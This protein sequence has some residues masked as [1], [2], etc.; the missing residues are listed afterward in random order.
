[1][2]DFLTPCRAQDARVDKRERFNRRLDAYRR[3]HEVS[4]GRYEALTSGV[5]E[6]QR[7]EQTRLLHQRWLE[8]RQARRHGGAKAGKGA[9]ARA[10][11][12][13]AGGG[14]MEAEARTTVTCA[15]GG[16]ASNSGTQVDNC[17]YID[18]SFYLML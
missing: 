3:R 10:E 11:G 6:Q 1:M 12:G 7:Q 13:A 15:G 2:G 9:A 17:F 8:G 14:T 16:A 18:D 5:V 4:L